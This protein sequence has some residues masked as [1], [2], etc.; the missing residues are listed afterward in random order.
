[1]PVLSALPFAMVI[2]P[3]GAELLFN[4]FLSGKAEW[5]DE[6]MPL[7][8]MVGTGFIIT[9]STAAGQN[10]LLISGPSLIGLMLRHNLPGYFLG[11][12]SARLFHMNER[13]CR[14]IAI[15]VDMPNGGLANQMGKGATVGL[16]P[17]ASGHSCTSRA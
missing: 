3:I 7:V 8:S 15:E 10:K 1:M 13:D 17:A 4:T 2:F 16:A 5:L 6:A 9:I 11:Y 14:T 12:W